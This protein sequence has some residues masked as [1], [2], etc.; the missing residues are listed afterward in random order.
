MTFI[1]EK[2]HRTHCMSKQ[3]GVRK[4]SAPVPLSLL[5]RAIGRWL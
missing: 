5:P 3:S 2:D 4:V 1:L